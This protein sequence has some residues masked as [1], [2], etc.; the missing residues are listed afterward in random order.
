MN[1]IAEYNIRIKPRFIEIQELQ[2]ITF[3]QYSMAMH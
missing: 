3:N 1:E 2:P